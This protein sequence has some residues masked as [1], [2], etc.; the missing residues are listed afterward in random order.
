MIFHP[1][2]RTIGCIISKQ[3][4]LHVFHRCL[5]FGF[6]SRDGNRFV[7]IHSDEIPSGTNAGFGGRWVYPA[8]ELRLNHPGTE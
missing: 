1:W 8:V 2:F 3:A 6:D 4:E 7:L 5:Q